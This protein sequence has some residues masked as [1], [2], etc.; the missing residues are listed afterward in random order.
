MTFTLD[1]LATSSA[2]EYVV[3]L[4]TDSLFTSPA[5]IEYTKTYLGSSSTD[6]DTEQDISGIAS[7]TYFWRVGRQVTGQCSSGVMSGSSTTHPSPE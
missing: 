6:T 1:W 2:D 4:D 5:K 3:Q 7:G